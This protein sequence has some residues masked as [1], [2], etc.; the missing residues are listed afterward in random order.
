MPKKSDGQS[1]ISKMLNIPIGILLEFLLSC[2][3]MSVGLGNVWRFPF[4]GK[5]NMK[6]SKSTEK[7][8]GGWR[9][10]LVLLQFQNE[11]TAPFIIQAKDLYVVH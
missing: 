9:V 10:K 6:K 7:K 4:T 11:T 8:E 5:L 2:I 3:A 1:P